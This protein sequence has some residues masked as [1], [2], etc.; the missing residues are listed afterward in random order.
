MKH[1]IAA[2]VGQPAAI[3]E[4]RGKIEKS[5]PTRSTKSE[6][7]DRQTEPW[8]GSQPALGGADLDLCR[9]G[10]GMGRASQSETTVAVALLGVSRE[11][12]S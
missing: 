5:V 7:K 11:A 10:A 4:I 12:F 3:G 2:I 8:L 9:K 1:C 6:R